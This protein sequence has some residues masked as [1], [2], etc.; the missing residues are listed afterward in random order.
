MSVGYNTSL[1]HDFRREK[2]DLLLSVPG[3]GSQLSLT[4]LAYLLDLGALNRMQ[5]ASLVGVVPL[6]RD[7]GPHRG[8]RGVRGDGVTLRSALYMAVLVASRRNPVLCEFYQCLLD[9]DK[10]KKV[11]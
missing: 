11:A 3:V 8:K 7:S 2:D 9:A 1:A 5:I 10:P 6:S 4:L